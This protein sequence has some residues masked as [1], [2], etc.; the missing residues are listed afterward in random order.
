MY[1]FSERG[2][3]N[4]DKYFTISYKP[5]MTIPAWPVEIKHSQECGCKCV[6]YIRLLLSLPTLYGSFPPFCMLNL[7]WPR[8]SLLKWLQIST[9]VEKKRGRIGVE[10][11]L[12]TRDGH[13]W[14]SWMWLAKKCRWMGGVW[15]ITK[16]VS[17]EA[18]FTS[19]YYRL[20]SIY[21][22]VF[23]YLGLHFC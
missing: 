17:R 5:A 12:Y 9:D 18:K 21:N 11:W 19:N 23:V 20:V 13:I 10:A 2:N 6:W 7:I 1:T 14:K 8:I 4:G 22:K 16:P 15:S 3:A